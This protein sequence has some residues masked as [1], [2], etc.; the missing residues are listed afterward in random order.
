[1]EYTCCICG[2]KCKGFGNNPFP[3]KIEGRCC[4]DCNMIVIAARIR[5]YKEEKDND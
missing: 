1:M 2:K 4:D 3:I 5:S